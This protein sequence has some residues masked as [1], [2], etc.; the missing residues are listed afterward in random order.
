M[1]QFN[2]PNEKVRQKLSERIYWKSIWSQNIS[3]G[4]I[5]YIIYIYIIYDYRGCLNLWEG[6]SNAPGREKLS[7][8]IFPDKRKKLTII[9]NFLT[10]VTQTSYP[11][12]VTQTFK[13]PYLQPGN[14]G[15]PLRWRL[16]AK[17]N[18]P[19]EQLYRVI[20]AIVPP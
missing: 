17:R 19:N 16:V 3:H 4:I 7:M 8:E 6:G 2:R 5:I 10:W 11:C 14:P 12:L 15:I 18:L 9:L 13:T 20:K 1:S